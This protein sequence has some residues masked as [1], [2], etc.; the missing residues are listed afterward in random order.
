MIKARSTE[1]DTATSSAQLTA[2]GPESMCGGE[3]DARFVDGEWS[4]VKPVG[5]L[6]QNEVFRARM[7]SLLGLKGGGESDH[8][9][10]PLERPFYVSSPFFSK[11][12][13]RKD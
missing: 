12:V 10:T 13:E 4:T 3:P 5:K 9:K 1:R 7:Q 6:V 11:M 2:S 8:D